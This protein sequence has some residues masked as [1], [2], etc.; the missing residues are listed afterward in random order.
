MG[1]FYQN[2]N[3]NPLKKKKNVMDEYPL[4]SFSSAKH[5]MEKYIFADANFFPSIMR[6]IHK[7][8][9]PR[10]LPVLI[11]EEKK[12]IFSLRDTYRALVPILHSMTY[13]IVKVCIV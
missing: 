1:N 4:L 10:P 7:R 12:V 6:S 2:I 3:S 5:N 11:E 13:L 8:K 9:P